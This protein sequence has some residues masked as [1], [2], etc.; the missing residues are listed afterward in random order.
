[1]NYDQLEKNWQKIASEQSE[2]TSTE[3]W[4]RL[5]GKLEKQGKPRSFMRSYGLMIA[6]SV[7]GLLLVSIFLIQEKQTVYYDDVLAYNDESRIIA[8][9]E[10]DLRSNE[11]YNISQVM[12]LHNAY[13][14][15][16]TNS[17]K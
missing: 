6:A 4:E 15:L 16:E 17:I 13:N 1:M 3:M 12:I 10:L 7:A 2:P 5:N 8:N 14:K 11:F 9:E